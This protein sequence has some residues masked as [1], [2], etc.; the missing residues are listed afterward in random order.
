MACEAGGDGTC[1]A[2]V[3]DSISVDK[4]ASSDGLDFF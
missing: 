3:A 4:K 1:V 2:G